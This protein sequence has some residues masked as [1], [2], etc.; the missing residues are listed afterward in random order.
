MI[1]DLFKTPSFRRPETTNVK[2]SGLLFHFSGFVVTFGF[3]D[4][5]EWQQKLINV[6]ECDGSEGL[7]TGDRLP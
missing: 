1:L 6:A 7:L 5:E 2:N 4:S 3:F